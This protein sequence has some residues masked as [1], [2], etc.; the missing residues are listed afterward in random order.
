M[1]RKTIT[2]LI[3]PLVVALVT[4][5]IAQ[6]TA[7]WTD[8]PHGRHM[9]VQPIGANKTGF[10]SMPPQTT[11]VA[12]TNSL[13]DERSIRNRALLSGSG[14]AAGDVDGDGLC[15]LYFSHL[16]GDNVLYRNLGG[17]KFE[18]I[19]A[20][21]GVACPGQDSMGAAFADYDGDGDLDLFVNA[22][23][24]GARV[25]RNDG[26]GRF[27]ETT[28]E[29]GIGS[30]RGST[31]IAIA[32]IEGDGD[33]DLYITNY[34]PVTIMDEPRTQFDFITDANGRPV[35]AT[36][37]GIPATDPSMT[38]RFE[39]S[40]SG[41]VLENGQPDDL[42]LNDGNG[43]F[44]RSVPF[45][46]EDGRALNE[47]H[48]D[49][50][51]TAMFRD[52]NGDGAPELFVCNDFFS[53]DRFWINDGSGRFS[54]I[55]KTAV[56]KDSLFSM[57]VDFADID[58]D[59]DLDHFTVDM[60]SPDHSMRQKQVAESKPVFWPV[61]VFDDRPQVKR[62]ML[63]LNRGDM[64]YAEIANFA[65]VAATDWSWG[66]VFLDVDLDGYDDL[67]VPNGQLRD[68]QNADLAREIEQL[69]T[70]RAI[71]TM[72]ILRMSL[73]TPRL[74]TPN[75]AF[76]NNGDRTFARAGN[77]WG[78][79][80]PIISQGIAL[81][82]L[83]NDG[84]LDV[85]LNNLLTTASLYRNDSA[86]PRIGVRLKGS[87][88][89]S[90]GVGARLE[91]HDGG[92]VHR[93][94]IIAGGRYLS[95]DDSI[96]TFPARG[97]EDATLI[98]KWRDGTQTILEDL[99]PN[100][101][102]EI[103]QSGSQRIVTPSPGDAQPW[104]KD[105]SAMLGHTHAERPFDDFGTQ[106]LLPN[107]FSQMGPG[108]AWHDFDGDGWDELLIGSGAGGRLAAYENRSG[109]LVR[110]SEAL[111]PVTNADH[112]GVLG[113]GPLAL[114]GISNYERAKSPV[115]P[116]LIL[117]PSSG[118]SGEMLAS[119]DAI[120]SS[121]S[122][123]DVDG[124]GD[125]DVF[126]GG[127]SKLGSYPAAAT[128]VLYANE[129]GALRELQRFQN[130]G[131][132]NA[133]LF[134]DL[135][136][137]GSP[138]LVLACDLDSVRVLKRVDGSFREVQ[139][140]GIS[141]LTGR[142]MGVA[143]GDFDGDGRLD[144][145]ATNWG[146]NTPSRPRD[147]HSLRYQFGDFSGNGAVDIIESVHD[148]ALGK[149]VPTRTLMTMGAA[150]PFTRAF[151]ETFDQ[152]S[153]SGVQEIY[154]AFLANGSTREVNTLETTVFLNR[155]EGS[156][157]FE[158]RA[159]PDEAQWSVAVAPCVAD[160][161]GDGF[162]DIFLSQNF[163]AVHP[164]EERHDAG[165]GLLMIGDGKGSFAAVDGQSSGIEVYGE[166]RAA[167]TADFNRDGRPDLVVTQNGNT[168]RLFENASGKPGVRIRLKGTGGNPSAVGARLRRI[169]DEFVGPMYEVTA[170]SGYLAQNSATRILAVGPSA[171]EVEVFWPG[172]RRTTHPIPQGTREL[173]LEQETD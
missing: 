93:A 112:S 96:R 21:A 94:E 168:T 98:V 167:A 147:G 131:I 118:Q 170:G 139:I 127:R 159:L 114:V 53:P 109:R 121:M 16:D 78:F 151:V 148:S 83:D 52:V 13:S 164:E 68:F 120:V 169:G 130:L 41:A 90:R 18:D 132:V 45:T 20:T 124:D 49:W 81:A 149:H 141:G 89:N 162:E 119:F 165:R 44:T 63:Q 50:G 7:V 37:N 106:A 27:T 15:D 9:D 111:F 10:T 43:R 157:R 23:N 39:L 153:R 95:G 36:V 42:F 70:S 91:W 108:V 154:G 66:A 160:F 28:D 138:E 135:D 80:A 58:H 55:A 17:W 72:D 62:N 38:N 26:A 143:G 172:G 85:V 74:D 11:G 8:N 145:I 34:R 146:T 33:L 3:P 125:L 103:S 73:K 104:F 2:R 57:G 19:T 100:R 137:D 24:N 14:V 31:S 152:Y 22:L 1:T 173:V 35:L 155:S 101:I 144:L 171:A 40:S 150:L 25:F 30:K 88:G 161:N 105:V 107:R 75:I 133:S 128:S 142:W 4:S 51:L 99:R 113:F 122:L 6:E 116:L 12:F 134:T 115:A 82:D 47:L 29:A 110:R 69:Q 54:P 156:L 92:R 123:S 97:E 102:Y 117:D 140:P 48:G 163:F 129:G 79:D 87:N 86:A 56:R 61:G 71:S 84:D 166:Q 32:D 136:A 76:R 77:E 60:L 158:A 59:G 126:L 64:T 67:L 65:G 5:T 46:D